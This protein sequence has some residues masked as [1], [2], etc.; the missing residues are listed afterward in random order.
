[1]LGRVLDLAQMSS[2]SWDCLEMEVSE[3]S[4]KLLKLKLL[5]LRIAPPGNF[6]SL[7]EP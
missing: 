7:I 2:S 3:D 4:L 1:M 5:R 6:R